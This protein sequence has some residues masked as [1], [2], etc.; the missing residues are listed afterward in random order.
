[1]NKLLHNKMHISISDEGHFVL[2]TEEIENIEKFGYINANLSI[3]A[4]SEAELE[5]CNIMPTDDFLSFK[6]CII[7]KNNVSVNYGLNSFPVNLQEN[8]ELVENCNVIKQ[9]NTVINN[10]DKSVIISKLSSAFVSHI[11]ANGNKKWFDKDKFLIHYCV[12]HWQ[13]EGQ[14]HKKTLEEMG[15]YP[16]SKHIWEKDAFRVQSDSS[17]STACYY[18]LLII[19]DL[20]RKECWFFE[21][22]NAASWFIEISAFCGFNSK[23]IN[24]SVSGADEK[25]NWF[26]DLKPNESYTTYPAVYGLIKGSFEE[27]VR[28]LIK[29][30]RK[31]SQSNLKEIPLV[32]NDF[33]N[34]SWAMPS[35]KNLIPLINAASYVGMEYFCIDAGWSE[36]GEWIPNDDIFGDYKFKGIIEYIKNKGIKP[37]VWFEFE[38]TTYKMADKFINEDWLLTRY[39]VPMP[40]HRP[41]LNMRNKAARE[42]LMARVDYVYSLGVRYI[43]NDYNYSTQIGT[44]VY[45]ESPAEGTMQNTLAFYTFIDEIKAKYPDMVLENCGG[46]AL[47]EDNGT[48][49]HFDLQ[50][51][52]DQED[53]TLY[54]SI[55]I[56]TMAMMPPE[57]AG[58]W[59][60]PYPMLYSYIG[61]TKIDDKFIK[62]W[63]DGEQTIFNMINGMIGILYL[64]GHIDNCD[65]K[66]LL[67]I[68]EGV[69]VYKTYRDW[70]RK[71]YPAFVMPMKH[72]SD[73]T[74]N[75]F[76]LIDETGEQMIL[77]VWNLQDVNNIVEIDLTRYNMEKVKKLYPTNFEGVTYVYEKNILS[78]KFNKHYSARL[79]KL[80]K[81]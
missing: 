64:S 26:V 21:F 72:L 15:M 67:L 79:F 2:S 19:E 31:A 22:E 61:Q 71:S 50:S 14:W 62:E 52:S 68:K 42:Y 45:G 66:N 63:A 24:V 59:S 80:S 39:N 76:G 8:F 44:T 5:N 41:L 40:H 75:A 33:M 18:P 27:A 47:R 11:G 17:W 13:G 34:C 10:S 25:Q 56:G 55:L 73:K 60:Y 28:E 70:L 69:S 6:N 23:W 43:K 53:Y 1:M 57:K 9:T 74:F 12:N 29:Y 81:I 49:K 65:E 20:E 77:A 7:Y 58:I 30:K 46:G 37:G 54:P 3:M 48:L 36:N 32:F 38:T 51:T 35:D 16:C 78:V 4:N